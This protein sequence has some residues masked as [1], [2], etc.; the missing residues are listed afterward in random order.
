MISTKT[1]KIAIVGKR[2]HPALSKITPLLSELSQ[3]FNQAFNH[4]HFNIVSGLADGA[5]QIASKVFVDAGNL[6]G[7]SNK[8]NLSAIMAFAKP[9][10]LDTIVDKATADTKEA[11]SN[12][13]PK[14]ISAPSEP[15]SAAFASS[16]T[17]TRTL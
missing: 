8:V 1:L 16:R 3:A 4:T 9:D 17:N 15:N 7:S 11:S 6:K 14:T 13:S 2:E 12:K 5:D 10:Y